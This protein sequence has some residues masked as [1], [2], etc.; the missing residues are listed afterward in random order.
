MT[1]WFWLAVLATVG[2]A[3]V[4]AV[5]YFGYFEFLPD[6]VAVHWDIYGQPDRFVD[7]GEAWMNFWLMPLVLV[8]MLGLTLVLPW[9]SPRSFEID[10]FRGGRGWIDCNW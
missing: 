4:S 3:A 1:R 5:A 8:A 6:K 7:R 2:A 10:R 9:L